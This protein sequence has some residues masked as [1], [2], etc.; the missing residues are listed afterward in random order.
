[1]R[2]LVL[3]LCLVALAVAAPAVASEQHPTLAEMEG[4][5]M[6]PVCHEPLNMSDSA[7]AKRIDAYIQRRIE[8]GDT[9]SEIKRK[10]VAQFG[11]SILADS[12]DRAAWLLPLLGAGLALVVLALAARHWVRVR[13]RDAREEPLDPDLDARVDDALARYDA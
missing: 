11:P 5:I 7:E 2:R 13:A 3:L 12:P 9:K 1:V 4:E 6:C 10:L 8:A